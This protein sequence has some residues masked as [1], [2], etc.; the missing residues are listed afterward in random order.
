MLAACGGASGL[1]GVCKAHVEEQLINPE[2]LQMLNFKPATAEEY[3]R[4]LSETSQEEAL[5]DWLER[6]GPKDLLEAI[7]ITNGTLENSPEVK[8]FTARVRAENSVG[9][10]ITKRAVCRAYEDDD[11]CFCFF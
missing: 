8:L 10:L 7:L 9:D 4:T 1:Q 5:G 3:A 11:A 2:T 6:M